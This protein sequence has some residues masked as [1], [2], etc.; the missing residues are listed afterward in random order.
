[1]GR[2]LLAVAVV[3]RPKYEITFG[4]S[5]RTDERTWPCR[6]VVISEG[7]TVSQ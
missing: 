6:E 1:M 3:E 4:P 2:V 7:S 5:A